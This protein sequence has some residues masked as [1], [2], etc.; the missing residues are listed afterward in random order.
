MPR[1]IEPID[2]RDRPA[3][4]RLTGEML[5]PSLDT[6][7][8]HCCATVGQRRGKAAEAAEAELGNALELA[9]ALMEAPG[10]ARMPI[11][12]GIQPDCQRES[13]PAG[14]SNPVGVHCGKGGGDG[15]TAGA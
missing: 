10:E 8:A 13:A 4:M 12:V 14:S 6:A 7:S 9:N 1:I 3:C 11:E 5:R 15:A 2:W